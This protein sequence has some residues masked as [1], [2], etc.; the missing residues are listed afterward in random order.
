LLNTISPHF[1]VLK[2]SLLGGFGVCQQWMELAGSREIDCWITS[3][4]ESNI[5]LNAIAQWTSHLNIDIE[6][7]LGTGM[8]YT[9]NIP[10]PLIVR[11]GRLGYDPQGKWEV[12]SIIS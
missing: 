7:G 3:T 9:N 12:E 4:L 11:D 1:L 5:A 10:C 2:P 6:Q 8:M